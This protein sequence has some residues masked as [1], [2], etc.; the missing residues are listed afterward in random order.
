MAKDHSKVGSSRDARRASSL[1]QGGAGSARQSGR[2]SVSSQTGRA[3][4]SA[5]K[6]SRSV[7]SRSGSTPRQGQARTTRTTE[8]ASASS[9]PRRSREATALL[10]ILISVVI[11]GLGELEIFGALHRAVYAFFT[12]LGG[13]SSFLLCALGVVGGVVALSHAPWAQRRWVFVELAVLQVVVS[14]FVAM[15]SFD[16]HYSVLDLH[17]AQEYGGLV[18]AV[19]A[20]ALHPLVGTVGGAIVIGLIGI[21]VVLSLLGVRIESTAQSLANLLRARSERPTALSEEDRSIERSKRSSSRSRRHNDVAEDSSAP[22]SLSELL[23]EVDDTPFDDEAGFDGERETTEYIDGGEIEALVGGGDLLGSDAVVETTANGLAEQELGGAPSSL[24]VHWKLPS[25]TLLRRGARQRLNRGELIERGATLQASL[26]THGVPVKIAGMTVGPTVTRYELELGEGI[27]VARILALHRDIAYAM[28]ATD[29]RILAP[30]P[31]RSAIGVEVPNRT[32]EVVTLGDVM[33]SPEMR[34]AEH[35]LEVPLGQDISGTAA[36]MNLAEMPHVLIAGATG[37]G[38]SSALN[39]LLTSILMRSTPDDV[40][41]ILIDP[42][43]VELGQYNRLPHLLTAVVVDPKKAANA[44]SWAVKE[45]ELRYDLLASF[46]VRDIAGYNALVKAQREGGTEDTTL[47]ELPFEEEEVETRGGSDLAADTGTSSSEE[48]ASLRH[49]PFIL[50]VVDELNDLMMAAARDVEDSICRIAQKAR[51]VGIHLVIATQRP[52][53]D[54]ITGVIKAN[55]PSR[56]AFAVASQAD[57]RVIL[58]HPGAE[59]LVGQGDMLLVTASS[60]HPR[61]IQSPWVSE[62]EV[63]GV[64]A[65]WVRQGD[66]RYVEGVEGSSESSSGGGGTSVG[67]GDELFDEAVR[68]VVMSQLGS[69][70]M[71]QR[72]LRVGF[73][74]AGRLMDLLEQN[75]IVGASE[76]SKAREVLMSVEEYEASH[77]S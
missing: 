71:L 45:M 75:G 15:V 19:I 41:L 24:G 63:R 64:V 59:K 58:D 10:W 6:G 27:K 16:V 57:S 74:R 47:D 60:S 23:G 44:L 34:R 53:V 9:T 30:I 49:L 2:G 76:G 40:R 38:K 55:V 36:V 28:A 42:K 4:S 25:P 46:G 26:L 67:G 69:T 72:K 13:P 65:S 18:G 43:R 39:S 31:G 7:T 61:R 66:P 3:N 50:V 21:V 8:T 77:F 11:G 70:S 5:R 22:L 1:P 52:S 14:A 29:V 12:A 54:V 37:A 33:S 20:G 56:M 73:A 32:R 68:L 62:D 48:E 51:A 35:P 17:R